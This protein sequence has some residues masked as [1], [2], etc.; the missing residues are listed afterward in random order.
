MATKPKTAASPADAI[1]RLISARDGL[2]E[3]RDLVAAAPR[4][5][6]EAVADV[7]RVIEALA[8]R[9]EPPVAILAQGAGGHG[10]LA[11]FMGAVSPQEYQ[12]VTPSAV[13]AWAVPALLRTAIERDL[14]AAYAMLPAA[15]STAEKAVELSRLDQ[16][17]GA[18]EAE[19][20]TTWWSAIAA[21]MALDP[22][23]V[24]GAV[25]IG[26]PA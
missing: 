10:D 17:I 20:A 4:A 19:I 11:H 21:G 6:E 16:R 12:P 25:L 9:F 1:A 26:L 13:L 8:D 15:M 2:R 5:L 14:G 7:D 22:P 3:E 18:I 23:D 24:S